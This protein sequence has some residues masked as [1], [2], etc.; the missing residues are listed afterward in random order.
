VSGSL[1]YPIRLNNKI[2]LMGVVGALMAAD[3]AVTRYSWT[4]RGSSMS[5]RDAEEDV[6][7]G[8]RGDRTA[9]RGAA[10]GERSQRTPPARD[11]GAV[12]LR[13]FV[14]SVVIAGGGSS[15]AHS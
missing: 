2:V 6:G 10:A 9:G 4:S 1:N 13:E 3:A 11:R 8:P 7:Y 14:S 5:T 15:G 12:V